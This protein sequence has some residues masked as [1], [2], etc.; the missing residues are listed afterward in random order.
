[1]FTRHEIVSTH[2]LWSLNREVNHFNDLN[3]CSCTLIYDEQLQ[4]LDVILL[5][6]LYLK[7]LTTFINNDLTIL[8]TL[9]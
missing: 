1:M 3:D 7:V 6:I 9:F 8:K 5:R 2:K 4:R